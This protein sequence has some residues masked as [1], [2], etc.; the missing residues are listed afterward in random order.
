MQPFKISKVK[1][2]VGGNVVSV[3]VAHAGV[4][5]TGQTFPYLCGFC[6]DK[7]DKPTAAF[8]SKKERLRHALSCPR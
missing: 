2:M 7:E 6:K 1:R 3:Y 5:G 8:R 4:E